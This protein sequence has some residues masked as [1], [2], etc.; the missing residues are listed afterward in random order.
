MERH[1]ANGLAIAEWLSE[2]PKVKSVNYPGLPTHP[3]HALAKQPANHD[4]QDDLPDQHAL[5]CASLAFGAPG[6]GGREQH[7]DDRKRKKARKS[8]RSR[9]RAPMVV[10]APH[11]DVPNGLAEEKFPNRA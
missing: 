4:Q 6:R 7:H 3:Q 11:A 9:S 2:H 8:R 5:G 1:S 10:G